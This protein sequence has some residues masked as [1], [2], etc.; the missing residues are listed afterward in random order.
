MAEAGRRMHGRTGPS[1]HLW[2][3]AFATGS[4]RVAVALQGP[5][6]CRVQHKEAYAAGV[7]AW[8]RGTAAGGAGAVIGGCLGAA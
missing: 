3:L 5:K 4:V 2:R 6:P 7:Q 8:L 1:S